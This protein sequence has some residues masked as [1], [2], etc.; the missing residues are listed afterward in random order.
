MLAA[1]SDVTLLQRG[2]AFLLLTPAF[3]IFLFVLGIRLLSDGLR[4]GR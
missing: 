4:K 2:G 1:A 3:L